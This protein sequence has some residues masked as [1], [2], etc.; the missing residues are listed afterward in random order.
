MSVDAAIQVAIADIKA[1][2]DVR[3]W[4]LKKGTEGVKLT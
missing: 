4:D 1:S 3:V 2:H